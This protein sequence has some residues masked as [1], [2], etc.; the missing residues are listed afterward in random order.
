MSAVF[1]FQHT[2]Q[3]LARPRRLIVWLAI[4]AGIGLLAANLTTMA[5]QVTS[6]DAYIQIS[7][8]MVFK[9][10]ALSSA[11]LTAAVVAQEVEQKTI[12]YML[13]RPIP[14]PAMLLARFFASAVV[15]MALALVAAVV[16]TCAVYGSQAFSNEI[17]FRDLRALAIGAF[18]YGA[19]FLV[20]TLLINRSM[21]V[22]LLFAFG[23]ES[24]APN[25]PGDTQY[26]TIFGHLMALSQH[27]Q[28]DN[29]AGPLGALAGQMGTN[30]IPE[31]VAWAAMF[32]LIAVC[33]T[34]ACI[35]FASFEYVPREDTD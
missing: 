18:A 2:L 10:L 22:C 17:F 4:I 16:V 33:L 6:L 21:P 30:V 23:W 9:V 15:A 13:T 25:L 35:L 31:N 8:G 20:V 5:R 32:G 3:E 24:I 1:V 26:V 12:V 14:R 7:G 27:P 29:S 19:V 28:L 34:F 11:I